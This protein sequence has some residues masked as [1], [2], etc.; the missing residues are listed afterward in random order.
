M[1]DNYT[2]VPD[3]IVFAGVLSFFLLICTSFSLFFATEDAENFRKCV[4]RERTNPD[5]CA[6]IIYG[7]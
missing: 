1:S 4:Q 6:L 7:R 3:A 5:E 2:Q